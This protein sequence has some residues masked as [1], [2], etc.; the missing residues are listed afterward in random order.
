MEDTL[1][2]MNDL[3][4]KRELNLNERLLACETEAGTM[5]TVIRD[6]GENTKDYIKELERVNL[7]R[8]T[9]PQDNIGE[10]HVEN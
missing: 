6:W 3:F 8:K 9:S 1:N 2:K 7:E 10:G 5:R 4:N